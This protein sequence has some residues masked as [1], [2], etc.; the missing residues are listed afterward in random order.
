LQLNFDLAYLI[1]ELEEVIYTRPLQGYELEP[2]KTKAYIEEML[3]LTQTKR[4][5]LECVD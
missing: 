1:A 3:I 5:E 4:Q 2:S